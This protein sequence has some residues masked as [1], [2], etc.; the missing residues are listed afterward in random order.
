MPLVWAHAEHIKLL[1]SLS[2]GAVFD[3]P[4]QPVHRYQRERRTPRVQPWRPDWRA[5]RIA[6]GRALR[7][8]LP[9]PAVVTWS[10]DDGLTHT[11]TPTRDTGLGVHAAELPPAPDAGRITFTWRPAAADGPTS[12][13]FVIG[14]E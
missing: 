2:D 5:T 6:P 10:L 1:R 13:K 14:V 4:P 12:E 9:E 8:D 3:L 11:E 7:L